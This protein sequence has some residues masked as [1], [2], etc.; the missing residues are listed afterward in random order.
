[1]A[2]YD[3]LAI[4]IRRD[5]GQRKETQIRLELDVVEL[6]VVVDPLAELAV[7]CPVAERH[8]RL[9]GRE[10]VAQNVVK[11]RSREAVGV[12]FLIDE[13]WRDTDRIARLPQQRDACA[14]LAAGIRG[15]LDRAVRAEGVNETWQVVVIT[16]ESE[17]RRVRQ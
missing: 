10:R 11:V 1:V 8:R 2:Q 17:R 14:R 6:E 5:G 9:G 15:G 12:Q 4:G 3:E 13:A 7:L 16:D